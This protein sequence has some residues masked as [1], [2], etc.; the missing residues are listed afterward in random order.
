MIARQLDRH[1]AQALIERVIAGMRGLK[2]AI[3]EDTADSIISMDVWDWSQ[4][5]GLFSLY[6]YYKETGDRDLLNYLTSWFDRHLE[7]GLPG[8]NVNT[9]CPLLT[10]SYLYEETGKPDYLKVCEEWADYAAVRM[11]RTPESGIAHTAVDSPN[12]GE[13]WDDTL[14]MT[15]LFL[16][17][18]G[19][20]L[21]REDYVE[22]SV[23]QFLV[24]LKYLTDTETGLF[25]HGWTFKEN[26]NF[27]RARWGRGNAWYTA[28]LVDYLDIVDVSPG[29][30]RF[31]LSSLERQAAKLTELQEPSGMWRTLLDD[32]SSYEETS[33]TAGFA[34]GLLKAV[35]KGYLDARYREPGL[36]ALQAVVGRIDADGAVQDV[37]YGTRMGHTLDF[38][39]QIPRCPMP[40]GQSMA[41]LMLAESLKHAAEPVQE[42]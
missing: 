17:R 9:M 7:R 30:R 20:L 24:H 31:L 11:P 22:E 5:V 16:G 35:R 33:A 25:F 14:Y 12:E 2:V 15:V 28:G 26:H 27:A 41:L 37:S 18:M 1:E 32:P 29:V 3:R 42:I 10:L 39:R 36:R 38:Y 40:Y 8:K 19:V 21:K 4:G 34:Y 23:R 13:L 6:L